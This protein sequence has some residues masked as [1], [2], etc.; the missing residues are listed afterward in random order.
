MK[1]IITIVC[2]VLMLLLSWSMLKTIKQPSFYEQG[3]NAFEAGDYEKALG[4]F[5]K[6]VE[7]KPNNSK[8]YL[9][10]GI[11]HLTMGSA[12]KSEQ[13]DL[14]IQDFSKA[15]EIKPDYVEALYNR[16]IAHSSYIHFN[17]QPLEGEN[18]QHYDAAI[19]D[20]DKVEQ[21][22]NS[23]TLLYAGRGA[24][25]YKSGDMLTAQKDMNKALSQQAQITKIAGKEKLGAV[26]YN[27]GLI[28][29]Q[30]MK[31]GQSFKS[32]EKAVSLN[33]S[34]A[35]AYGELLG[36]YMMVQ[37]Y[38]DAVSYAEKALYFTKEANIPAW[39]D[40]VFYY[41]YLQG[42][43]YYQL[44]NYEKAVRSL[45]L[46]LADESEHNTIKPCAQ[47]YLAL[48]KKK[49]G[50]AQEA[51][52]LADEAFKNIASIPQISSAKKNFYKALAYYARGD[53]RKTEEFLKKV[54]KDNEEYKVGNLFDYTV[55]AYYRLGLIY[56]AK[57]KKRTAISYFKKA[58]EEISTSPVPLKSKVSYINELIK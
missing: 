2:I 25:Q 4:F 21:L 54:I 18:K 41:Q 47:I 26:Y 51:R 45:G 16:G 35:P 12:E 32:F 53:S 57:N 38:H 43:A 28:F 10:R 8:I 44:E 14:A 55:E 42:V 23:F 17:G 27:Y 56:A 31:L 39:N 30:M 5:D 50:N 52:Q 46:M 24:L 37:N 58:R 7:K 3:T 48:S 49:L 20:L 13:L 34:L 22:D 15:L 19:S 29:N 36:V 1:A 33:S 11:T 6:S 9:S 40:K